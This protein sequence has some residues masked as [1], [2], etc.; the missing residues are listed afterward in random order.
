[1]EKLDI[2][3]PYDL[4]SDRTKWL[5]GRFAEVIDSRL[6]NAMAQLD[7]TYGILDASQFV[8]PQALVDYKE[9]L[10]EQTHEQAMG[11][12]TGFR[13]LA[14]DLMNG[15]PVGT[16]VSELDDANRLQEDAK[17][18]AG[19][20]PGLDAE[21]SFAMDYI[22][23]N[24]VGIETRNR[25]FNINTMVPMISKSGAQIYSLTFD[26]NLL[27]NAEEFDA[28]ETDSK[29]KPVYVNGNLG[30]TIIKNTMLSYAH[31]DLMDFG[32]NSFTDKDADAYLA[33]IHTN[34]SPL[35]DDALGSIALMVDSYQKASDVSYVDSFAEWMPTSDAVDDIAWSVQYG[36]H[37]DIDYRISGVR[38]QFVDLNGE[39]AIDLDTVDFT[40]PVT[41][42]NFAELNAH[43]SVA[44]TYEY[45]AI[46][47]DMISNFTPD[48]SKH[49]EK[50]KPVVG[51][52][53]DLMNDPNG[54][55][56]HSWGDDLLEM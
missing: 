41:L 56:L 49:F 40:K 1:M 22:G 48:K 42:G 37:S 44:E 10:A 8:S 13:E 11:E 29:F 47:Q 31:S 33:Y 4:K 23:R 52:Y 7:R 25:Y 50:P 21:Q 19:L 35:K 55:V 53:S 14:K 43:T 32:D 20:G 51:T 30:D 45:L 26:K 9:H 54:S 3:A 24:R 2:N 34:G 27:D 39:T 5:L 28:L 18:V 6:D 17:F 46:G 36:E 16:V 38:G 15:M 12:A